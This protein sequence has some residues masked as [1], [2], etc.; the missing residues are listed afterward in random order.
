MKIKTAKISETQISTRFAKICTRENYP[1][2]AEVPTADS[3]TYIMNTFQQALDL[4]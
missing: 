1:P 2:Y 4:G 3:A